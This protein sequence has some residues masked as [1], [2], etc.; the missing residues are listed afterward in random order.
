MQHHSV[1]NQVWKVLSSILDGVPEWIFERVL[2]YNFL[3]CYADVYSGDY[4]RV[5]M[6][7]SVASS[8]MYKT[9]R[10]NG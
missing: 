4:L 5:C 6:L 1:Y 2:L 9:T 10:H 8:L 3:L 7:I